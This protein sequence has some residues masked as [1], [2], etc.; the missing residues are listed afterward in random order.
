MT[1]RL[2]LT[3]YLFLVPALALVATFVL[4]PIGAVIYYSFTEYDIITTP[5]WVGLKNYEHLIADP[6]FWKALTNSVVYLVATPIVI[7]LSILLALMVNR[8]LPGISLFRALYFVP[9]VSG[10]IAI[11]ISWR[12]LFERNGMINSILISTGI[13][14]E[15]V[16]WLTNPDFVLPIAFFF[17]VWAGLRY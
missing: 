3:P 16:Q 9:A 15:P 2:S 14:H 12:W 6:T 8:R 17:T 7:V 4:Y 13:L 1:R 10:S 5:Q 11:G